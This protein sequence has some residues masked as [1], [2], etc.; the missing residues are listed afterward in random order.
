MSNL[1]FGQNY[2]KLVLCLEFKLWFV[3]FTFKIVVSAI[4]VLRDFKLLA[5]DHGSARVYVG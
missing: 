2:F 3:E 1:I 4:A 5:F